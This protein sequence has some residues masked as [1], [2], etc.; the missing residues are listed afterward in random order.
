MARLGLPLALNALL[1]LFSF[2]QA[3]DDAPL[4][5]VG[6]AAVSEK[7]LEPLANLTELVPN[8]SY[9]ARIPCL[10]CPVKLDRDEVVHR[11]NNLVRT[12]MAPQ[13]SPAAHHE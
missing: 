6:Q 3:Y 1:L 2:C 5:C 13:C 11:E 9:F 12:K 8:V 7:C 10:D 4:E